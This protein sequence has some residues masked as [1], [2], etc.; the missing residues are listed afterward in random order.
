MNANTNIL[1]HRRRRPGFTLAELLVVTGIIVMALT[2]MVPSI[3]SMFTAP[4]DGQAEGT[5]GAMLSLAR[6]YAIE[7]GVYTLV[8]GQRGVD[9]EYWLAVFF[10]PRASGSKFVPPKG[11]R[12]QQINGF[13]G[14]GE[15]SDRHVTGSEY[16]TTLDADETFLEFATFHVIFTPEGLLTTTMVPDFDSSHVIFSGTSK[17]KVWDWND[18]DDTPT[19]KETGVR[20]VTVYEHKELQL[21]P[22]RQAYLDEHGRFIVINPYTGRV[23][24]T[25]QE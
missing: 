20:A 4:A 10:K 16:M 19:L 6:G 21:R 14:F 18:T 3:H 8:H 25:E 1:S 23:I 11:T 5:F 24:D 2:V 12:P 22:D 9:G 7:H 15:V 17:E 13:R